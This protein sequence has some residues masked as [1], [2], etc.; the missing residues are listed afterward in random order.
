MQEA[1]DGRQPQGSK[2]RGWQHGREAQLRGK[3]ME[4]GKTDRDTDRHTERQRPRHRE[5][6]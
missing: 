2:K 6:E 5:K 1:A 3:E 4:G